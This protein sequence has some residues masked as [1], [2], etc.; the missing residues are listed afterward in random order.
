MDTDVLVVGGGPAGL[1]T[2]LHATR[3]GLSATVVDARE[4]VIDKACGE[5]LMPSGVRALARLGIRP[6]PARPFVGVRFVETR[7]G[8]RR[9]GAGRFPRESGLGI[10]RL[11]LHEAL[12]SAAESAGVRRIV[13]RVTDTRQDAES[14]SALVKH[15]SGE[16]WLRGRWLVAADGLRSP[17]RRRLGLE[18]PP[19]R[20]ERM[21]LR[22]HLHVRPWTDHVEVHWAP[23]VEAYTTPVDDDT[24]GIALLF[25]MDTER[26]GGATPF[27]R[28]LARFPALQALVD[29]AEDASHVRGAG[30]FEQR[31]A[32]RTA[33]RILLVGDAAGYLDPLTGEGLK[34][35]LLG[36]EAVIDAIMDEDPERWERDWRHITRRYYLGTGAL[37]SITRVPLLRRAMLPV[38]ATAPWLMRLAIGVLDDDPL[39]EPSPLVTARSP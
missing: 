14:A 4:G 22:K 2:A 24:V 7:D 25:G 9:E 21:G 15:D 16:V 34:L 3:R 1:A 33:G 26:G 36:A 39:P 17:I 19:R 10:R 35:G 18:L 8:V 13:G 6:R 27:D 28:L 20:D 32:R 38:V 12:A 37:L 30:P 23:G 11:V 31:V 5:G 29:G